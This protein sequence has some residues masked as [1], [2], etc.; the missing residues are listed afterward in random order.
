MRHIVFEYRDEYTHGEWR[1]QEC[2]MRSLEECISFYGLGFCEYRIISD[3]E[4][5]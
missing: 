1:R 3:E 5:L 4:V 2:T